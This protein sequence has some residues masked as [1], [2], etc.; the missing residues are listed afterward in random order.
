[1]LLD[2]CRNMIASLSRLWC[3]N[4]LRALELEVKSLES[5]S[6]IKTDRKTLF[7]LPFSST[8][9]E[10]DL[11]FFSIQACK[12]RIS[13]YI[14]FV[15]LCRR[16]PWGILTPDLWLG[17]TADLGQVGQRWRQKRIEGLWKTRTRILDELSFSDLNRQFSK[18]FYRSTWSF[19]LE[20]CIICCI[21]VLWP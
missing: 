19:R 6:S 12:T 5:K 1:M 16:T 15:K 13:E 8:L 9:I 20:K 11:S 21:S 7:V 10:S 18:H 2:S 4:L 3:S 17:L 14:F